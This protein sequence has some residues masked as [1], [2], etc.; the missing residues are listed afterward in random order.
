MS[1][2]TRECL[3]FK[4]FTGSMASELHKHGFSLQCLPNSQAQIKFPSLQAFSPFPTMI[5]TLSYSFSHSV[6]YWLVVLNAIFNSISISLWQVNLSL[7]STCFI[8]LYSAKYSCQAI[9]HFPTLPVLN[10]SCSNDN[11]QP[12][13]RNWPVRGS[14]QHHCILKFCC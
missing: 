11:H 3:V 4:K 6:F 14:N 9:G 12:I 13:E 2:C 5:S 7:L 8:Y 1:E 10:E